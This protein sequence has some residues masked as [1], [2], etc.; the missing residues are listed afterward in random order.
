MEAVRLIEQRLIE[1]LWVN[2]IESFSWLSNSNSN[3]N[4]K[5]VRCWFTCEISLAAVSLVNNIRRAVYLFF[6]F[7]LAIC[8]DNIFPSFTQ[9]KNP[10]IYRGKLLA[11]SL[12]WWIRQ[13][14]VNN[15]LFL[16]LIYPF[17]YAVLHKLMWN[18]C[19]CNPPLSRV[20]RVA[21]LIRQLD[22]SPVHKVKPSVTDLWREIHIHT[23]LLRLLYSSEMCHQ[24]TWII[25]MARYSRL[26]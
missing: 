7:V 5:I 9:I 23:I 1:L 13:D 20:R 6:C 21:D 19:C 2:A 8:S 26:K 14:S 11:E 12:V 16:R 15:L 18:W 17:F 10:F 3:A 22:K 4:S 24:S 25:A